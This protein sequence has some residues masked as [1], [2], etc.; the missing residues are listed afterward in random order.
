MRDKSLS[1][2]DYDSKHYI[3]IH[4]APCLFTL[5]FSGDIKF[6]EGTWNY[7]YFFSLVAL[8]A[9][10]NCIQAPPP[11]PVPANPSA[12]A[13]VPPQEPSATPAPWV[14]LIYYMVDVSGIWFIFIV[15]FVSLSNVII[16]WLYIP[17]ISGHLQ[18]YLLQ[19][20]Q[21]CQHLQWLYRKLPFCI[22]SHWLFHNWLSLWLIFCSNANRYILNIFIEM[23]SVKYLYKGTFS[24]VNSFVKTSWFHFE[25]VS[26]CNFQALTWGFRLE[27]VSLVVSDY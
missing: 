26:H 11:A 6:E 1:F 3:K 5:I 27:I 25:I 17:Y 9:V 8:I 16:C 10:D 14:L 12:P 7:Y 18:L 24:C 20:P 2:I 21:L 23:I 13:S 19:L 22:V 15:M 4:W